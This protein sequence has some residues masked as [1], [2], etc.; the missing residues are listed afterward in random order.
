MYSGGLGATSGVGGA[1]FAGGAGGTASGAD[2]ALP[3]T[4]IGVIE[5]MIAGFVLLAAGQALARILPRF[6]RDKG[7]SVRAGRTRRVGGIQSGSPQRV[8]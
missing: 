2:A 8:G 7:G 5:L 6:H 3:F 4:G 1:L